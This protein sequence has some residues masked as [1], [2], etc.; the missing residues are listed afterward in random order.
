MKN[1]YITPVHGG[2]K[3]IPRKNMK[4]FLGMPMLDRFAV[5]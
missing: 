2:S 1:L 3:H 4:P 5:S